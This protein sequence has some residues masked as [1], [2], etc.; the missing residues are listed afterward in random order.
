MV[1]ILKIFYFISIALGNWPK[2]PLVWF[3]SDNVL[4]MFLYKSFMVAYLILTSLSHFEFIFVYGTSTYSNFIDL[5]MAAQLP[6][7]TCWRDCQGRYIKGIFRAETQRRGKS[8]GLERFLE[9]NNPRLGDW[10][11]MVYE[12]WGRSVW[13]WASLTGQHGAITRTLEEKHIWRWQVPFG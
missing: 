4:L 8:N 9:L 6:S 1:P 5:H 10:F 7:T 11:E 2:K 12:R 3:L 13:C